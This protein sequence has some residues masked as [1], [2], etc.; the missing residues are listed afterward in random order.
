MFGAF[1][2]LWKPSGFAHPHVQELLGV[3]H[4]PL[5]REGGALLAP[6]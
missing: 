5:P 3:A 6:E 1:K 4:P 2:V